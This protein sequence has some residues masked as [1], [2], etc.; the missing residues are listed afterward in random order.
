M[1]ILYTLHVTAFDT[2]LGGYKKETET[3]REY[4]ICDILYFDNSYKYR[5][6][7]LNKFVGNDNVF[8]KA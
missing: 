5:F 1:K 4:M 3:S 2:I 8:N 7:D 6:S